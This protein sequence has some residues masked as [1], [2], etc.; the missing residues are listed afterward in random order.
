M[1]TS[2][3]IHSTNRRLLNRGEVE[4][5]YDDS[6]NEVQHNLGLY[7]GEASGWVLDKIEYVYVNIAKYKAIRRILSY[8]N[9]NKNC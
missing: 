1:T 9:T 6:V 2:P 3:Y 4:E 7:F 8:T 5:Q